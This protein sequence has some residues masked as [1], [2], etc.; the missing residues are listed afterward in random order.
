MSVASVTAQ[1]EGKA[2]GSCKPGLLL[3]LHKQ[4]DKPED[5]RM[6]ACSRPTNHF[7]IDIYYYYFNFFTKIH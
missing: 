6:F 1:F 2:L 7:Y 4:A 5:N 3:R